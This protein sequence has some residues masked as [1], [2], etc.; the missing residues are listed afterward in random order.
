MLSPA[1]AV[2]FEVLKKVAAGGYASDLLLRDSA[3]LDSR[4]AALASEIAFGCLRFQ[5]QLDF[6]I[7]HFAGRALKLDPEVRIALRMAIYQVRYLER[8]P[9][10]AA[11]GESV[12]LV[13]RAHKRS[14]AGLVNAVLRKVTR[15]AV[16]W[17][18]RATELSCPAWM[19]QRWTA[20]WDSS[21]AEGIARAALRPPET[22]V[23]SVK[24]APNL[25]PEELPGCYRLETGTPPPGAR[26][27][28]IGSQS[29]VPLL[30][31]RPGDRFLDLCAAPGNKTAQ[32]LETPVDAIACDLH[33]NRIRMLD[34]IDA[35]RVVLDASAPLPFRRSFDRILVD[36][37]CTGT[38]TLGRNPEIK[39]RLQPSDMGRLHELQ[40]RILRNALVLLSRAGRLVYSTCSLEEEENRGVVSAVLEGDPGYRVTEALQRIPGREPGDGFFAAAIERAAG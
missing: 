39:W 18:D 25:Q 19:L 6:L 12:E 38:G 9:E 2:A 37:P 8:V 21:T 20:R 32:A 4:D 10:H 16:R 7:D 33:W 29:V 22:W 23:R 34:G 1:R 13:K 15:A 11:V 3:R 28:D 31:L 35:R 40:V 14:A 30:R 26:I 17:P 24:P 36:A 27:Q 5:A